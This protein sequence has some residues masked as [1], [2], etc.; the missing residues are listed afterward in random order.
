[1]FVLEPNRSLYAGLGLQVDRGYRPPLLGRITASQFDSIVRIV[2]DRNLIAEP[3]S[4]GSQ[5]DMHPAVVYKVEI[6]AW[7]MI[8]RYR[9]TPDES[10]PTAK[11]LAKLITAS[12]TEVIMWE[13]D[14]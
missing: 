14:K 3:T 9:T 13:M 4:L 2:L 11:L 5:A 8:N 10:P 1:M 12:G 7:G 6:S